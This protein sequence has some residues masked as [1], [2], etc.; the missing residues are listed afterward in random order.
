MRLRYLRQQHHRPRSGT[1]LVETAVV[2]PIFFALIFAFI[3][4]GHC[5]MTIHAMN[6]A[7][8]RAARIGVGEEATT[9]Q[10]V[11]VAKA[12]LGSAI[13]AEHENIQ[14]WVKDAS[15]FDD[16]NMDP[17][18]V[19]YEDLPDVLLENLESR[20]LFVVRVQVP[21]SEFGILGPRWIKSLD[22]YG[23][24]VMRKE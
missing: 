24:S 22:L 19:T 18:S 7:A 2:L 20:D 16:P 9:T 4:F 11:N 8:R 1:A 15:V 5:F 13:N 10:V 17:D 6:S 12:V 23:Q 14:V 3:E 21:Y